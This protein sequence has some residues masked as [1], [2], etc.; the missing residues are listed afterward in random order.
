M[1]N[2]RPP[3]RALPQNERRDSP[4]LGVLFRSGAN[5]RLFRIVLVDAAAPVFLGHR[6]WLGPHAASQAF[7]RDQGADV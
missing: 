6:V 3:G 1:T 7:D 5:Q 2:T 4:E